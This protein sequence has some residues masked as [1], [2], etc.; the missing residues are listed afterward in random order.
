MTLSGNLGRDPELRFT[1]SGSAVATFSIAVYAGKDQSGQ[2]RD[3]YWFDIVAWGDLA[4]NVVESF[5]VGDRVTVHGSLQ[6]RKWT[7]AEGENRSK[8]EVRA[9]DVA[10]SV[11]WATAEIHR[12][13]RRFADGDGGG[14]G[15]FIDEEP[16]RVGA[17]DWWPG[18]HSGAP[19]ER[20]LQG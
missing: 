5:R 8:V 17:G 9:D 1:S 19:P 7:T 6:Q 18:V 20:M 13:E 11:K 12:T 16:F 15:S 2:P 10:A 3:P 14:G 4:D